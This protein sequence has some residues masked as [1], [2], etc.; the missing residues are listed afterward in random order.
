MI[1]PK[2]S[3]LSLIID[4]AL[5]LSRPDETATHNNDQQLKASI[6]C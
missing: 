2:A 1:Y 3:M 6:S 5:E 4:A